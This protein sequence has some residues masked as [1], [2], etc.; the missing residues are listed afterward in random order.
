MTELD[1]DELK[2][3]SRNFTDELIKDGVQSYSITFDNGFKVTFA[4][5]K[6]S[7]YRQQ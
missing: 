2:Q 7:A 1:I 5:K 4:D 3:Q 6:S